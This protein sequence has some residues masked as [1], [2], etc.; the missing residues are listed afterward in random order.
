MAT[1][2]WR[3]GAAKV[4]QVTTITYSAYTSG[5]TYTLTI[6][7]KDVS[8]T[9]T[10]SSLANVIDGLVAAIQVA[11]ATEPEYAEFTATNDT[12][13][14]LTATTQGVPFTIA[15]TATGGITATVTATTA[16]TGPN[17]F[18]NADNWVGNVAPSAGDDIVLQDSAVSILYALEDT[19]TNYGDIAIKGSYTGS[20]GL[21][22]ENPAGYREYRPRFLKLGDGTGSFSLTVGQGTGGQSNRILVD[23]NAGTVLCVVYGT[24]QQASGSERPFVLKNTD[25]SST[26]DVYS[27]LVTIDA[28]TSGAMSAVRLTPSGTNTGANASVLIG[29]GVSAGAITQHGGTIEVRGAATSI[30]ATG[31]TAKFSNAATCPTVK[32]GSGASINWESTSGITTKLFVY[33]QGTIEFGGNASTKAVA[34]CEVYS[35]GAIRDPVAIVTWTAG[36]QIM[37]CKLSDI[38]LDIGLSRTITPS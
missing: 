9:A 11:A 25:A 28:D 17:F 1:K 23:A 36:I 13:L 21:P 8:Y 16:A 3:G 14:V 31:G 12:G 26:L 18:D 29:T 5:Q 22:S 6:N 35:T 20:V 10:A 37:G 27:G 34:A 7:G 4:A 33:S 30:F 32:V 19:G 38:Q 15:S 2:I 24:G